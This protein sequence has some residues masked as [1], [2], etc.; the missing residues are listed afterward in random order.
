MRR[1]PSC[2]AT[3]DQI[4]HSD[5]HPTKINL[6]RPL[7]IQQVL[8]AAPPASG[9]DANPAASMTELNDDQIDQFMNRGAQTQ[10]FNVSILGD[11]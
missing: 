6:K 3:T 2:V 1:S 9:P 4:S 8:A 5:S 11:V 10:Q 7:L